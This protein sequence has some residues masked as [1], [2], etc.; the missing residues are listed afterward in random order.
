M[1]PV[2]DVPTSRHGLETPDT[3]ALEMRAVV[4]DR[5]TPRGLQ[6]NSRGHSKAGH[7]EGNSSFREPPGT[8]G[9]WRGGEVGAPN[10]GEL[11]R[12]Q[13]RQEPQSCF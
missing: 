3:E 8:P 2:P 9:G 7:S 10:G 5:K 13:N 1:K 4:S 11:T 12:Q 6:E